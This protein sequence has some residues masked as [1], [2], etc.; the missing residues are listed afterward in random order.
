MEPELR[1]TGISAV[2]GVPWGTHFCHFYETKEDVL[3]IL[4]P[5]FKTG[6]ENNEFCM[7][8][9]SDPLGE[10][11]AKS[12][13][14]QAV[15]DAD[16]YLAAGHI[17]IVQQTFLLASHQTSPS[18][19]VETVP[20][21]ESYLRG[22]F[23]AGRVNDG[24]N[25]KLTEALAKGLEGMRVN[26][27]EAWLTEE[28]RKDLV[29]YEKR[30]DETLAGQRMIVLYS[31][32]LAGSSAPEIFD[33]AHTHQFAV[34]RRWGNWEVVE[35]PELK[36]A[37]AEIKRLNEKFDQRVIER[38]KELAIA[39]EQLK[40]EIA[41][42]WRAEDRIRLIIDTIPVMA[43]SVQTDGVVDFLNQRW[44]D[45]A[46]FSLEQ[47]VADPT[48]LIHPQ[49]T[50]RVM[51]TWHAQMALGEAYGDEMRLRGADGVYRWFLVRTA[52]LR[53]E[54]GEVVKWYGVSTDIEDRKRA[55]EALG[56]SEARLQAAVDAA[57]IGLWEWDLVSGKI[58]WLGHHEKLFG[59]ARGEFDRSYASFEERV[60]PEDLEE[61]SR[62]V[63]HAIVNRSEYVHEYRVIWPDGSIHW[64]AGRGRFVYND[65][66]QPR[67]MYGAVLDTTE[68]K[69]AEQTLRKAEERFR[70]LIEHSADGISLIDSEG[71][72]VYASPATRRILG[73][74]MEE[75]QTLRMDLI[76]PGDHDMVLNAW[77]D[78]LATPGKLICLQY[79]F[80]YIDGTWRW[81]DVTAHSLLS[82][83]SVQALVVNFRDI[84]ERKLTEEKLSESESQLAEAQRLAHTGSWT[85]DLRTG[86]ITWSDELY[87]ICGLRAQDAHAVEH[88]DGL[89]YDQVPFLDPADRDLAMRTVESALKTGEPYGA[90][91][92]ILPRG[93]EERTVHSR[94]S[95]V[96]NQLGT[97]IR[98]IGAIQD[99]TERKCAEEQLKATSEQLRAL[100]ARLQSA[101]ETEAT[102]IAREIH[103]ELGGALTSLRWDLEELYDCLSEPADSSQ[104]AALRKKIVAM[105]AL[106]ETT[107]DTLRRLASELRPVALDDLGL[108]E[109]IE[110]Q[111]LQFQT[112][113]GIDVRYECFLEKVDLNSQQSISVFRILQE[114]MTNILRHARATQVT[115]TMKQEA[116]EFSLTIKD[117]GRG[118]TEK[119]KSDVHSMGLLGMRERAHLIGA[120]IDVTGVHGKGTVVKLR[121]PL[122]ESAK[123][124]EDVQ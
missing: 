85:W 104:L 89:P 36:Q 83:P 118:I 72:V 100:S 17:E 19:Q 115:I 96:R 45:Y 105:T 57:N 53:D 8:V 10:E 26:G 31:Y 76:H 5:F 56:A 102:R 78:L 27:N 38:T 13:L 68:R 92:R 81:L 43:W 11:D 12:A 113:S 119:E 30:L 28:D 46:G 112:R 34:V 60:H 79:R 88:P 109:A 52:P 95:V 71:A 117:D 122:L 15:A 33:V 58:L 74:T 121:V 69:R 4:V 70:A 9:V 54:S 120:Q 65:T 108:V 63:Q 103:D 39:S 62:V 67:Y 91:Y 94:G 44:M 49:D 35:I 66:G 2:G 21:A 48:G 82:D 107:V 101:K 32:P 55:E 61:L 25:K 124:T 87:R 77:K 98:M 86:A 116:G 3:D 51:E 64:V 114:A 22:G 80:R 40:K 7:W 23:V 75:V 90:Y 123:V 18:A 24:W 106:T 73:L 111:A 1:E 47:Y 93:G 110:W 37:K 99:V 20:H 29:Q 14:R 97:P 41:E 84:T 42:R 59:F 50:P 6:L 16:R